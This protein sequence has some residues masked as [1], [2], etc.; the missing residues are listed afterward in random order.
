[1]EIYIMAICEIC[2]QRIQP[3]HSQSQRNYYR[4][5]LW[6]LA[7]ATW[8]NWIQGY[9]IWDMPILLEWKTFLHGIIKAMTH[10]RTSTTLNKEQYSELIETAIEVADFLGVKIPEAI[11]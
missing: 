3:K 10:R 1:M 5:C 4:M 8:Y 11:K 9:Y 6:I 2:K 7:E